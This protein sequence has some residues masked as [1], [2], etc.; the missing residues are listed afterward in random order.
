MG[1]TPSLAR[2]IIGIVMAV[3]FGPLYWVYWFFDKDYC[4]GSG[5]KSL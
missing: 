5:S 2:S 4:R 3:L 1:K